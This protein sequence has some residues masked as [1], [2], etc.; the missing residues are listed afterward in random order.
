MES[1]TVIGSYLSPYVRKV[2]V[3]LDLKGIPYAVDPIVPFFGND[4]FSR[5]SPLRRIPVLIDGDVT[6]CDST[7]ICEYLE[8]RYE[9]API[10]PTSPADR[11]RARWLEEYADSRMGEVFI[12][13]YFNQLVI[14]RAVWGEGP[15]EQ[16]LNKTVNEE[17]P[18]VLDYLEA[19]VPEAGYFFDPS[20]PCIADIAIAAMFRNAAFARF[21][22]DAVRWPRTAAYVSRCLGAPPF[23]RLADFEQILLRT[24]I[25]D[26]RVALAAAGAPLSETT[27]GSSQPRRGVM[28]I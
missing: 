22:I 17:I 28:S 1:V 27:W 18:A 9:A 23:E 20:R 3:C 5:L 24:G 21:S 13:R 4:E 14:R 7:I 10:Y 25:P 2:L 11:A 12:W 19:Q 16:V 8:E 6:L 26:H 15:D